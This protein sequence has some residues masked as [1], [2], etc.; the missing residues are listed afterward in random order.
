M[1]WITSS[2]SV[3]SVIRLKPILEEILFCTNLIGI[4]NSQNII[5]NQKILK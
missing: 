2:E 5:T 3:N 4:F 1:H